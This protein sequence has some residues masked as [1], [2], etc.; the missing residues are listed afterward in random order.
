MDSLARELQH[1]QQEVGGSLMMVSGELAKH[2][3]A[4]ATPA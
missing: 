3:I 1:R 4:D 2:S